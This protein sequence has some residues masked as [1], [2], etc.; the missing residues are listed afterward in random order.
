MR[1]MRGAR[2]KISGELKRRGHKIF[3]SLPAPAT[4]PHPHK[5]K[6]K[7]HFYVVL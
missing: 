4:A 2:V 1:I 6:R 5:D 7:C 3:Q